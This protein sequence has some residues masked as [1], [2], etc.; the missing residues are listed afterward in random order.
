V[1]PK[2]VFFETPEQLRAWFEQHASTEIELWVGMRRKASGLPTISW[3]EAVDEAL[4]VGWIDGVRYRVDDTG[5][6]TRFSP[7]KRGSTWSA[8]N[9]A[10]VAK[11]TAEGRMQPAGL[12]AS[13]ARLE[14]RTAIYSYEN[15]PVIRELAA[16][17]TDRLQANTRAWAWW[18]AQ[19]PFYRKQAS[20]WVAS[21]RQQATRERRLE[22]LIADCEAGR[23]I[24]PMTYGKRSRPT[25]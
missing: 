23:L 6:T 1:D 24:K 21:A 3:S 15:P 10:K 17:E 11:L 5:Y 25:T 12:I 22:T 4:C 20:F 9:V 8:V 19:A 16:E 18:T 13:E 7:R 2:P 14:S